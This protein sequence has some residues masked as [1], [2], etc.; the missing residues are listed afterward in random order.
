M[1]IRNIVTMLYLIVNTTMYLDQIIG[2]TGHGRS[3][4]IRTVNVSRGVFA[5]NLK[6]A[7]DDRN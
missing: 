4:A 2:V 1:S 3:T 5:F 7:A 6:I